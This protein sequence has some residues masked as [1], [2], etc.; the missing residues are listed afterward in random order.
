M[1]KKKKISKSFLGFLLASIFIWFIITLSKEYTTSLTFKV[2]YKNIPQNKLL[3]KEPLKELDVIV[4]STGFNILKSRFIQKKIILDANSLYRKSVDTYYFLTKNQIKKIQKQLHSGITLKEVVRDSIYLKLGSLTSKKVPIKANLQIDYHIGYDL[5]KEIQIIP[6]SLLISGPEG[7]V[8]QINELELNPL[9]LKDVKEDFSEKVA[10]KK[11]QL[12]NLKINTEFVIV[13]GN[14]QKFTEGSF[15]MPFEII[16]L[17]E[18]IKL[19]ILTKTVE[20]TYIVALSEFNKIDKELF[21]VVCDYN[22]TK[23]NNLNYL[24]PTVVLKPSM[25]KSL[26]IVPNKI[27]FLIQ[28]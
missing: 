4:V 11:A 20:L 17:P 26:K 7:K 8:N 23:Q 10:I 19:T 5:Y 16:N 27:D 13:K 15:E 3:Q 18:D 1:S 14:V 25:I 22:L 28:K 6:D 9:K 2:T 12:K 24:I 21:K